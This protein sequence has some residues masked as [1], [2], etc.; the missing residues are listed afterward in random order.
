MNLHLRKLL[1]VPFIVYSGFL[2]GQGLPK[3]NFQPIV[4]PYVSP[5]IDEFGNT[6]NRMRRDHETAVKGCVD[7]LHQSYSG[8]TS[9][10]KV[11]DGM[12]TAYV[13]D[14]ANYSVCTETQVYVKNGRITSI[15]D[16]RSGQFITVKSSGMIYNNKSYA[17][18]EGDYYD[19]TLRVYFFE[20]FNEYIEKSQEAYESGIRN[21]EA[22]NTKAAINNFTESLKYDERNTQ[23]LYQR[24]YAYLIL[25]EF[26][27]AINDFNDLIRKGVEHSLVYY[28]RGQCH[29]YTG[30]AYSAIQDYS[31]ALGL[32]P[33]DQLRSDIY[34]ARAWDYYQLGKYQ[35]MLEDCNFLIQSNPSNAYH[36]YTRGSA[37]SGLD[38]NYGAISDYTSAIK[39]DPSIS[40]F[41]NNRGWSKFELN[42]LKGALEDVNKAI[43]L[44]PSNSVALDSRAEIYFNLKEYQKAIENCNAALE[45]DSSLTNCYFIRGRAKYRTNDK[46]GACEDWNKASNNGHEEAMKYIIDYCQ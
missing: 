44:D 42:N 34:V 38:D 32:S 45:I 6:I 43:E 16:D 9:F 26:N 12:H 31:E 41:W 19:K 3:M 28:L 18:L 40:M 37:K 24:G 46:D 8:L 22:S 7:Q 4:Q 30:N 13:A 14:E 11:L 27:S 2:Y 21:L 20:V 35:S 33:A 10:V 25:S 17:I 39:L 15:K 29:T 23:A 1:F 36:F 5:P